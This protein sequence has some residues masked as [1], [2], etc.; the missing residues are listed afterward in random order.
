[1]INIL[2]VDVED[3]QQST[4]DSRLPI[5]ERALN[6]AYRLL[7]ILADF[8]VH[9][10]FFVQTMVAERYPELVRRIAAQGHEIASHGHNHVP[11]FDLSPAEFAD[12]LRRSLNVLANI[13]PHRV[14]G[15]R[16]PDF[17]IRQD[18]LW[19][20][21]ILRKNGIEYSSSIF[22]FRGSR[23]GIPGTAVQPHQLADGLME[24]PLSVVHFAGRNWPVAGGGYLRLLPYWIT[25]WAIRRINA[26]GRPAVVY[27]HPYELDPDEMREFKGRIPW[28][29][30]LSQSLN[31][32][33]TESKLRSLLQ[34]FQFGP[35]S[36]V[37]QREPSCH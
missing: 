1:M 23:Y 8:G 36:E 5:S 30:Y 21:D 29:L 9:G 26:E 3:W 25:R 13:H 35:I 14:R 4:L 33:R 19:A 37:V 27:V 32:H 12:D 28:R 16:A 24:I 11:L 15:Y 17:S 2:T 10:T 34:E 6:N 18:T 31:R 20:L 7:D 22:P